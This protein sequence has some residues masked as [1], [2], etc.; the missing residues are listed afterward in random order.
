[1]R[2]MGQEITEAVA[3]GLEGPEHEPIE[4]SPHGEHAGVSIDAAR[5]ASTS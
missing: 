2:R 4:R 5:V 3:R 1:M